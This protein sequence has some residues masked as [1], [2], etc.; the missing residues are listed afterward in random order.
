[1]FKL[2][3][4]SI[5]VIS[6][7][8]GMCIFHLNC[9]V[10]PCLIN[11]YRTTEWEYWDCVTTDCFESYSFKAT[12]QYSHSPVLHV[13]NEIH[14]SI[15]SPWTIN[16]LPENISVFYHTDSH[17]K[18]HWQST[19]HSKPTLYVWIGI[20]SSIDHLWT[21]V[22]WS[23]HQQLS[24]FRLPH[25][26]LVQRS[27]TRSP[28]LYMWTAMRS[29]SWSTIRVQSCTL[30]LDLYLMQDI[31]LYRQGRIHTVSRICVKPASDLPLIWVM[32]SHFQ[33]NYYKITWLWNTWRDY[34]SQSCIC[35][36]WVYKW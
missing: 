32:T 27:H 19:V 34:E 35:L 31:W 3:V 16:N 14:S 21:W 13:W 25:G 1:M 26:L 28:V 11:I 2:Q 30:E 12:H 29:H 36:E 10:R 7:K 8:S 22:T 4:C 6:L 5:C 33:R 18:V 17:E 23:G 20:W 9:I 24:L 15:G